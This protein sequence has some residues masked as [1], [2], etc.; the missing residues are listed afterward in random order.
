MNDD[1]IKAVAEKVHGYQWKYASQHYD[2]LAAACKE[3][4]AERDNTEEMDAFAH[5]LQQVMIRRIGF[6]LAQ[7]YALICCNAEEFI[8]AFHKTFCKEDK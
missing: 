1:I 2:V 8:S 7:V 6:E 5:H 3:W 4:L